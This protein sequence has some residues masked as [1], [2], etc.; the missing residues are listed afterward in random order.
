MTRLFSAA[1]VA[2]GCLVFP[3]SAWAVPTQI[4]YQGFLTDTEGLAIDDQVSLELALYPAP[5]GGAPVWGPFVYSSVRVEDGHFSLILGEE[6]QPGVDAE[7]LSGGEVWLDFIIDGAPLSPRQRVI[8][9]PYAQVA[10]D[11]ER[12]GGQPADRYLTVDELDPSAV[13]QPDDLGL[14][15]TTNQYGDLEGRPDLEAFL[16]ADG[17]VALAAPWDLGGQPLSGAV[18]AGG[19][20]PPEPASSGQ[21]YFDAASGWLS[22]FD[23]TAWR[24][25]DDVAADLSCAGCVDE[26]ELG[27]QLAEV[28]LTGQWVDLLGAP[29]MASYI[30]ADG[31]VPMAGDLDLSGHGLLGASFEVVEDLTEVVNQPG[32]VVFNSATGRLEVGDGD[33]WW[34]ATGALDPGGDLAVSSIVATS[35][36]TATNISAQQLAISESVSVGG[37]LEVSGGFS[38]NGVDMVALVDEVQGLQGALL[39]AEAERWC[40]ANCGAHHHPCSELV[41]DGH[42][43]T[44]QVVGELS[45]GPCGDGLGI[46]SDGVCCR[47]LTCGSAGVSCGEIDDGC[48]GA[49]DC[50]GCGVDEV[51]S[52]DGAC[53]ATSATCGGI[54]CPSLPGYRHQCNEQR[55]CRYTRRLV[56]EDWHQHDR[57][58]YIPPGSFP[59]GQGPEDPLSFQWNLPQH[60]VTFAD[61]YL[62]SELEVTVTQYEACVAAGAC[63]SASIP[64]GD[65][66]LYPFGLSGSD[67]GRTRHPQNGL[68]RVSATAVCAWLA[69]RLPTEAEWE[70]AATGSLHRAYPWGND[71]PSCAADHGSFKLAA[72]EAGLG[73]FQE[74]CGTGGTLE[75]GTSV[76][77]LSAS[78]VAD[79]SGNLSEWVEDCW[80]GS[81]EE[82]PAD[83]SA[84]TQGCEGSNGILRGGNYRHAP[85]VNLALAMR[86]ESN[87]EAADGSTG[88]RCV[89]DL[90]P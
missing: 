46:C 12:L 2:I 17:S 36:L 32:R 83:G 6:G 74:G 31:S 16:R 50:G 21:L 52:P 42:A 63:A 19:A 23:G 88:A 30:H 8:S 28:A 82:A 51:C 24:L 20:Q 3:I 38:L 65:A 45:G 4:P 9:V 73:D 49:L 69:G 26:Q 7:V 84:W 77:G 68:S 25:L 87:P 40:L 90:A 35:S 56:A 55:H 18:I 86:H 78:G 44:C 66:A 76:G 33:L 72:D 80:H 10:A 29:D 79:M 81:Y 14:A 89:R 53:L 70:R 22:V 67:N 27:F 1:L 5:E 54:V 13:L 43:Q 48:G 11:A 34:P 41:C 15:A 57:W 64:G 60:Q 59:M 62:V 71:A 85:G 47:P 61:G 58:I 37:G 39:D 75:V